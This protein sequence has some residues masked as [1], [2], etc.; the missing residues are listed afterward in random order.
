MA[1]K[2]RRA[3]RSRRPAPRPTASPDEARLLRLAG[4]L[5]AL[6][7]DASTPD[8]ALA[9]ALARLARAHAPSRHARLGLGAPHE[10]A[11]AWAREQVRVALADLLARAARAGLAR[12]DLDAAALAWLVLA[13]A[14]ALQHEPPDAVEDRLEALRSLI[15]PVAAP[16]RTPR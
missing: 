9:E 7:R 1:P 2:R 11:L 6:A 4:E 10:L 14:E 12:R 13:G 16:S 15:R 3:R 5:A 8:V